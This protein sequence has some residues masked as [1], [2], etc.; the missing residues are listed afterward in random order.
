MYDKA[1]G[2]FYTAEAGTSQFW[3]D[4]KAYRQNSVQEFMNTISEML[5]S[6]IANVPVIF[7]S[8]TFDTNFTNPFGM[9]GFDGL[10]ARAFGTGESGA[11]AAAP[12]YA[13]CEESPR[14]QWLIAITAPQEN[15]EFADEISLTAAFDSFQSLGAKGFFLDWDAAQADAGSSQ[16]ANF[17]EFKQKMKPQ[18]LARYKPDIISYPVNPQVGGYCA[19][20]APGVWWLPS[21]RQGKTNYIGD[22][23]AAYTFMADDRSYVW[24]LEGTKTITTK[25]SP[26]EN[27]GI[28]FPKN[29]SVS[30]KKDTYSFSVSDVPTV[31]AGSNFITLFPMETAID[32]I[33]RLN[34]LIAKAK[35]LD[36]D[37]RMANDSL[38]R[39][40]SVLKNGQ[41]QIAFQMAHSSWQ[42]LANLIGADIWIEG[43]K[44]DSYSFDGPAARAKASGGMVL[45]IDTDQ[46]PPLSPYAASFNF[47]SKTDSSFELWLAAT[48]PEEGSP[49]AFSVDGGALTPIAA[50]ED[51]IIPY[52]PGLAW[53]KVGIINT[54]AGQHSISFILTGKRP[55]DGRY[56]FDIDS[57][58]LSP[59]GFVPNGLNRP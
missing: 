30:K 49:V 55:T 3:L 40:N 34:D 1:S 17:S 27:P 43:E 7:N 16:L 4:L 51:N 57:V 12:A 45:S 21:A 44:C 13:L 15:G 26:A 29:S 38:K 37:T 25:L 58:V 20:L 11:V 9:T 5:K 8:S 39:A 52:A 6:S 19:R 22:G 32:E 23:L 46:N 2:K 24:A 48:P 31:I 28:I 56:Y 41:F 36:I 53:Y 10:A 33:E 54:F 59:T 18:E 35:A 50:Q 42:T 47:N 14:T